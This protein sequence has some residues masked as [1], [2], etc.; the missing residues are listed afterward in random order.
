MIGIKLYNNISDIIYKFLPNNQYS[1]GEDVTDAKGILVRSAKLHDVEFEDSLLAIARAGAGTNNIPIDRCTDLGIAVFNTP[2]ANANAVKE[3]VLCSM[4]LTGRKIVTGIEWMKEQAKLGTPDI[5]N[6]VEKQ[7][8]KFAGPEVKGKRLAVIGLG[9]IGVM[10]ANGAKNGLGCEVAGYDPFLSVGA[11]WNLT[12]SIENAKTITAVLTDSDFVTLHVPLNKNTE[13]LISKKEIELLKTGAVVMNFSR[14]GL[15]DD[16]AV[17]EALD[18]GKLRYY[19]TDFPSEKL[20]A[21]EK[22][23]CIP[24]L[25][26]STPE[27]EENCASMAAE[28]IKDFIEN[29]NVVNS[30]NFPPC[31]LMRSSENRITVLSRIDN[32]ILGEITSA[33]S[34]F[35]YSVDN[36]IN[37]SNSKVAYT[38]IDLP[39]GPCDDCVKKLEAIEG[40]VKV[41]MI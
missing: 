37:K 23:I 16:D 31:E 24:H 9:A 19:V 2:G 5:E 21:N 1:V 10:V 17:L 7:K 11:A 26:A 3:L 22:V 34:S 20:L 12:S 15:V 36:M 29:G 28:Q 41:R 38:I 6:V 27:S 33:I 25:G 39:E 18:S 13:N 35:G 14:G 8:S 30:I 40:V 4:L 32:S